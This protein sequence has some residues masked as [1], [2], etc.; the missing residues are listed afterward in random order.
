MNYFKL[1]KKASTF[2]DPISG[3]NISGS[4]VIALKREPKTKKFQSALSAGH[5]MM[6][7][8]KNYTD[9][10]G[11]LPQA[12]EVS[13]N[14]H[15]LIIKA[16]KLGFDD[17]DISKLEEAIQAV[18]SATTKAKKKSAQIDLEDLFED[19]ESSYA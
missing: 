3:V 17:E 13:E 2:F 15:E 9:A 7:T 19:L 5:I 16:K 6:A 10:G 4:E 18:E 14:D 8:E 1:G 11:V 12:N